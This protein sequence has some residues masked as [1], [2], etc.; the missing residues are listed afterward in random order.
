MAGRDGANHQLLVSR[1]PADQGVIA[2]E[3]K[4]KLSVEFIERVFM[5]SATAYK[6][7]FYAG[8]SLTGDFWDGRAVDRQINGPLEISNYWITEFLQSDLRT[9]GPAGTKRLAIALRTAIQRAPNA[10]AKQELISC[11]RLL[12]NQA[13]RMIS[14]GRLAETYR[15]SADSAQC[16]RDQ[17]PRDALFDEQFRFDVGE[18]DQHLVYRAVELDNGGILIAPDK[19]FDDTFVRSQVRGVA[20]R[21]RFTTEGKIVDEQLRKSR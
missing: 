3:T 12:R 16:L 13:G 19:Q 8:R 1:F 11:A 9:T 7:A 2:E 6:S 20:D 15:L 10:S 21:V 5:K 4:G 14:P 17:F 18:F